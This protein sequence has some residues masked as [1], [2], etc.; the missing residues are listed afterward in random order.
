MVLRVPD[1]PHFET[2]IVEGVEIMWDD[3]SD[4]PYAMHLADES[5]DLLPGE[6]EVGREWVCAVYV[7]KDGRPHKSL[8]RI[9]HWRRVDRLPWLKPWK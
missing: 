8:E 6:P 7:A 4:S 2:A 1:A 5:F 9:C 3:G